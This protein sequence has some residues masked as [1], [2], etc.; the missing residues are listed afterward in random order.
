MCG[1]TTW[2][3]SII[4]WWTLD[5]HKPGSC[6]CLWT[7]LCVDVYFGFSIVYLSL[8]GSHS[9]KLEEKTAAFG[10]SHCL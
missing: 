2:C 3:L 5:H 9:C 6:G 7:S 10:A 1:G 8:E 4:P